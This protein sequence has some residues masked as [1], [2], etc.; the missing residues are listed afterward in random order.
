MS[1]C[2]PDL[3]LHHNYRHQSICSAVPEG[4][5]SVLN[6]MTGMNMMMLLEGY[7][8][9]CEQ[10]CHLKVLMMPALNNS[11]LYSLQQRLALVLEP[12]SSV[13][14]SLQLKQEQEQVLVSVLEQAPYCSVSYSHLLKQEP[15]PAL[16]A[17]TAR[18][19]SHRLTKMLM[20]RLQQAA[21]MAQSV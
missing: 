1:D 3:R 8:A 7:K 20:E 16:A 12:Y 15:V 2:R 19:V 9:L 11:V 21:C 17:Y 18:N 6:M 13:L 4:H 10:H 14:Y 5:S